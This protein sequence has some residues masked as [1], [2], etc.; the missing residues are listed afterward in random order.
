MLEHEAQVIDGYVLFK[1][2]EQTL[3]YTP[4]GLVVSDGWVTDWIILYNHQREWAQDGTL[5]FYDEISEAI[6]RI[7]E[8]NVLYELFK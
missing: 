5:S 4:S 3:E 7:C 2:K 1:H 8:D 6:D